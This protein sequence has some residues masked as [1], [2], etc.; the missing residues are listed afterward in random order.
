MRARDRVLDAA[1]ELTLSGRDKQKLHAAAHRKKE[2]LSPAEKRQDAELHAMQARCAA[3]HPRA[4]RSLARWVQRS[5]DARTHAWLRASH[6]ARLARQTGNHVTATRFSSPPSS[7]PPPPASRCGPSPF[8]FPGAGTIELRTEGPRKK[9]GGA[10]RTCTS[11]KRLSRKLLPSC[12]L[13]K[14]Q[15][16]TTHAKAKLITL[17]PN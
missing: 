5:I 15:T 7:S 4:C 9:R 13:R 10:S 11:S 8:R 3:L 1:Q 16:P 17:K 2:P 6:K 12:R 14:Q